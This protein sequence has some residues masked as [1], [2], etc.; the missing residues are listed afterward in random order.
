MNKYKDGQI[1]NDAANQ[2]MYFPFELQIKI[3]EKT[4]RSEWNPEFYN[5]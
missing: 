4:L 2:K 1:V 3:E 5:Y